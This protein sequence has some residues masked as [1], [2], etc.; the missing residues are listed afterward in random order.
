MIYESRFDNSIRREW[1]A[2]AARS[3]AMR[4]DQHPDRLV[5]DPRRVS[6]KVVAAGGSAASVAEAEPPAV[7]RAEKLPLLDPA[8]AER[9][10]GVRATVGND[11][12]QVPFADHRH[13]RPGD[14][15]RP[16]APLGDFNNSAK[17]NPFGHRSGFPEN[18]TVSFEKA[19]A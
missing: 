13:P 9:A 4:S 2:E 15:D 19:G 14:L 3:I 6:M 5:D 17:I 11:H 8:R 18:R 16:T 1:L 10:A 12:D 7:E